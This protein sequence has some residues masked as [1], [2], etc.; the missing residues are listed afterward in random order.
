MKFS[1]RSVI[2]LGY[3]L[4]TIIAASLAGLPA[5]AAEDDVVLALPT[6]ATLFAPFYIAESGGFYKKHNLN[7]SIRLV[8]GPGAANAVVAGSADFSS[9]SGLTLMRAVAKGAPLVAIG[10]TS[11]ELDVRV[12]VSKKALA[13]MGVTAASPFESRV[14]ALKGRTIAI[15]AVSGIPDGVLRYILAQAGV[16]RDDLRVTPL[17]PD[18]M[19]AA[20]QSNTVDGI[21][22]LVPTTLQA[23]AAGNVVLIKDPAE[24]KS[25][26]ALSPFP[27][28][29][30]IANTDT[31]KKRPQVCSN[32][33][34][35]IKEAETFMSTRQQDAVEML[36]ARFPSLPPEVLSQALQKTVKSINRSV[37]VSANSLE[38]V[39]KLALAV[40]FMQEAEKVSPL[41][42]LY[43]NA[44]NK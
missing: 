3:A 40:G 22:F 19:L 7:V 13:E 23:E 38:N 27:F 43:T 6:T 41:S 26:S 37:A 42:K 11:S 9:S 16:S 2:A 20:L 36:K 31:C 25:L 34:A 39:E 5:K 28:N 17:Q 8:L 18:A 24:E 29:L 15:D 33:L 35:A 32:M 12:I 1:K 44:Y 10:E 30:I 4:T 14:K 21:A